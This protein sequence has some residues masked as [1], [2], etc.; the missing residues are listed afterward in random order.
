MRNTDKDR[1]PSKARKR[2]LADARCALRKLAGW[3]E[4]IG[5]EQRTA[6]LQAML[7]RVTEIGASLEAWRAR[8]DREAM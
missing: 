6:E 4:D 5:A 3:A 8:T 1:D 7:E 2:A